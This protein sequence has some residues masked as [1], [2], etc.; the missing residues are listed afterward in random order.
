[1]KKKQNSFIKILKIKDENNDLINKFI[2]EGRNEDGFFSIY[3]KNLDKSFRVAPP[4]VAM[5]FSF[6]CQPERLYK[7]TNQKLPFGCHA[8]QKYNPE[9]WSN[10]IDFDF[11]K[12]K[13]KLLSNIMFNIKR[14]LVKILEKLTNHNL[15]R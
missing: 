7:M 5:H 3:A 10:F 9:F 4:D 11:L 2:N 12:F 1:M 15:F 6:E 8:W 14:N 13:Q